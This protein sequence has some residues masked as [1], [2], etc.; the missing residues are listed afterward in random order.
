MAYR[1]NKVVC[2]WCGYK[3]PRPI[4]FSYGRGIN[5]AAPLIATE[6]PSKQVTFTCKGCGKKYIVTA[7]KC[8]YFNTRKGEE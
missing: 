2:P 4:G 5:N 7:E 6:Y 1:K 8:V 3:E